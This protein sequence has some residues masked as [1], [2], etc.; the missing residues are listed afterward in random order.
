MNMGDFCVYYNRDL[1]ILEGIS[2]D[3]NFIESG[4]EKLDDFFKSILLP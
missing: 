1:S 3:C 2:L 4:L